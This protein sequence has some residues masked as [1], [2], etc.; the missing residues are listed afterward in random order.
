MLAYTTRQESFP[1]RRGK[2]EEEEEE[3][4]EGEG[5]GEGDAHSLTTPNT[6]GRPGM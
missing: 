3:E 4:K 6:K 5:A 1:V 2:E